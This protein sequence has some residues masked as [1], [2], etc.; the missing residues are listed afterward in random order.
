MEDGLNGN[1]R[2]ED[3]G[4]DESI[5][6][7]DAGSRYSKNGY[8]G[9]KHI[10]DDDIKYY[11]S[12]IRTTIGPNGALYVVM[13]ACYAGSLSKDGFETT[14]GTNEGLTQDEKNVFKFKDAEHKQHYPLERSDKLAPTLILEACTSRERN[15][16]I[17]VK[18][19]EYGS[20]SYMVY[21]T[22][23][24]NKIST[25][26]PSFEKAI[27]TNVKNS[28]L[29]PKNQHLVTETSYKTK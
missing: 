2:D 9:R 20:L 6:P 16:E 4:W 21:L 18:G 13:D 29:W 22:L 17:S 10:I 8:N 3:D 11:V 19:K 1:K 14:R 24:N 27:K 25:D 12:Q 5:V 15:T 7:Y 26:L 23:K 28:R